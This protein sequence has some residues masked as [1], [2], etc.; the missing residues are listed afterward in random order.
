M[1]DSIMGGEGGGGMS[2]EK[3][4]D[5]AQFMTAMF[6]PNSAKS[7]DMTEY[8]KLVRPVNPRAMNIAY[9]EY[10]FQPDKGRVPGA[11][12]RTRTG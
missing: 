9:V 7:P 4:A 6:G 3:V 10:D 11:P 5:Y 1:R 12:S 8:K 2:D